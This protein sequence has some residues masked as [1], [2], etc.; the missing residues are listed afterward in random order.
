MAIV[1][2]M[3]SEKES[4]ETTIEWT[5]TILH[6]RGRDWCP[7]T[8]WGTILGSDLAN[9]A[10]ESGRDV[11]AF[12]FLTGSRSRDGLGLAFVG[13]TCSSD[14]GSRISMNKYG[15]AGQFKGKDAY[16]AEVKFTLWFSISFNKRNSSI[17]RPL[18]TK[19]ATTLEW[20]MTLTR[21]ETLGCSM[22]GGA[23]DTWITRMGPDWATTP[24]VGLPAASATSPT[25]STVRAASA[26]SPSGAASATAWTRAN[27]ATGT[28]TTTTARPT[29]NGCRRTAP[30]PARCVAVISKC[31]D[32]ERQ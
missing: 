2:E 8:D 1:D 21:K 14:K 20:T 31:S 15:P 5:E 32:R 12:V 19:S 24:T 30:S 10:R 4:L 17:R 7:V 29:P 25:M 26:S 22:E 18:P 6:A 13:T 3:Y 9:I 23:M 11:D 27:I 16:T 28:P